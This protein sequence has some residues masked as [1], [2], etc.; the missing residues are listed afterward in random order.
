MLNLQEQVITTSKSSPAAQNRFIYYPDHLVRLPGPGMPVGEIIK[1]LGTEPIFNGVLKG[2]L[3]EPF[4]P[5]ESNGITDMSVGAFLR[6]RF[7]DQMVDNIA[8]AVFHGIYAGDLDQLSAQAIIPG[9]FHWQKE[10]GSLAKAA[11]LLSWHGERFRRPWDF[12]TVRETKFGAWFDQPIEPKPGGDAFHAIGTSS[13]YTFKGGIERLALELIRYL[14]ALP[15][16]A[17]ELGTRVTS[18]QLAA[19]PGSEA[20]INR[21][22]KVIAIPLR[23]NHTWEDSVG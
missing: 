18:L 16:V 22:S 19:A 17:I 2:M 21:N 10:Y 23:S 4:R 8:S 20:N 6:S 3:K 15:N 12:D 11:A 1:T 7:G 14:K 13:V 9:I 5:S